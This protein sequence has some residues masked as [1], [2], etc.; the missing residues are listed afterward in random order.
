MRSKMNFWNFGLGDGYPQYS[1]AQRIPYSVQRE[2]SGP[3]GSN[4]TMKIPISK[5]G[6]RERDGG[7]REATE[8]LRHI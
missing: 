1:S 7:Q 5:Q 3:I 4:V 2:E 6:I 8:P